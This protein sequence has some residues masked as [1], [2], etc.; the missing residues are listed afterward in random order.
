MEVVS[1]NCELSRLSGIA[2]AKLGERAQGAERFFYG[3]WARIQWKASRK[4]AAAEEHNT[5]YDLH[6]PGRQQ[7][8]FTSCPRWGT[9]DEDFAA[10]VVKVAEDCGSRV[11]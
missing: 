8:A 3:L 9:D 10:K 5:P 11:E 7:S 1:I 2:G 4:E 6:S